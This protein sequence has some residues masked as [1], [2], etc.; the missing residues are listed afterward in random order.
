M[1]LSV[2]EKGITTCCII[3][4]SSGIKHSFPS[5]CSENHNPLKLQEGFFGQISLRNMQ[6]YP[7]LLSLLFTVSCRINLGKIIFACFLLS[8]CTEV[9]LYFWHWEE[10][11]N[12]QFV[13]FPDQQHQYQLGPRTHPRPI[14]QETLAGPIICVQETVQVSLVP[15]VISSVSIT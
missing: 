8:T 4:S 9:K 6:T 5:L 1:R 13:G 3:A 7:L 10:S 14:Q 11:S 2:K 15:T 12:L